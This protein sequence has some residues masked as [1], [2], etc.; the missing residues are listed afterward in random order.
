M[1]INYS[2]NYSGFYTREGKPIYHDDIII[3]EMDD[4]SQAHIVE[5]SNG[6]WMWGDY[7]LRDVVENGNPRVVGL[8]QVQL[9]KSLDGY[10]QDIKYWSI[11]RGLHKADP[12]KQMVKLMEEIGELANGLNKSNDKVVI[13]SVGDVFVVLTILCQQ[14]NINLTDC[15]E[16][17]YN[18]IKERKGQLVNG[19][20]VKEQDLKKEK[21]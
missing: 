4:K 1:N 15:V 8:K 17:A 7:F 21:L 12:M 9:F 3:A 20:F 6:K 11:R 18:E 19:I 5:Y 13:D 16:A 14:L 10:H 2:R